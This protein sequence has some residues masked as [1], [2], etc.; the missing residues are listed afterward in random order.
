MNRP[1]YKYTKTWTGHGSILE[2][3]VRSAYK[4]DNKKTDVSPCIALVA[5]SSL[6]MF[7]VPANNNSTR[8]ITCQENVDRRFTLSSKV[9]WISKT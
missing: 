8:S 9:L 5:G 6:R 7:A 3:N 2:V 4:E 1:Y